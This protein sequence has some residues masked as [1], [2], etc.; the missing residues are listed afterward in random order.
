MQRRVDT[1]FWRFSQTLYDRAGVAGACLSLQDRHGL[2][3]NLLLLCVWAGHEGNRLSRADMAELASRVADWQASVVRPLRGVRQW[4]KHQDAA[5]VELAERLRAGVKAQELAAEQL[6]QAVLYDALQA[7][8]DARTASPGPRLAMANLG[9][10]FVW[11]SREPGV[12]DAADL[13]QILTAAFG[14][15]LR[16][17]D[18][19]W[20]IQDGGDTLTA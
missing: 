13:A 8:A 4:L 7:G 17:L 11:L 1:P 16:P 10:Y 14:E 5:P 2:D 9:A 15:T 19:I 12:A 20:Q 6:Q 18:A 3:V